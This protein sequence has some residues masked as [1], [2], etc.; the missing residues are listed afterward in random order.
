[1]A[2]EAALTANSESTSAAGDFVPPAS[3]ILDARL[4][5]SWE[6]N[7]T[8]WTAAVREQRIPSRRAGADAAIVAACS[9]RDARRVL[10]VG[11]GEGWLARAIARE[12]CHVLGIDGSAGLIAQAAAL[13][14]PG[15]SFAAVSYETLIRDA[16]AVAGPWDLIVCNFALLGDPLSPLLG[17]LAQR[18]APD[19]RILIQTVHP[20]TAMGD[21][22][23]ECGWREEQFQGFG[24]AFPAT[25][26]WYF[27]TLASWHRELEDAGLMMHAMEEP[28][29]P[30]T[31]RP[32]S[33][34]LHCASR[35]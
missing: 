26:P 33:M 7:A 15:A 5:D 25:M 2:R 34:L 31:R 24:V 10:D 11:C 19:G 20:W 12:P 1:M 23:Y 29:H 9:G 6:S 35:S 13:P 21:G 22:P 32:L 8:A 18:L 14:V 3:P 16:Q 30:E 4:R 28:L 27:R 17:A